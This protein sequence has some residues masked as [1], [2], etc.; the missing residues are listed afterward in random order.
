VPGSEC[1][2]ELFLFDY[3]GCHSLPSRKRKRGGSREGLDNN[4]MH[5]EAHGRGRTALRPPPQWHNRASQPPNPRVP[6][7]PS[8][9]TVPRAV[10][11]HSSRRESK[12]LY[13]ESSARVAHRV[14]RLWDR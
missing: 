3:E 7:G 5:V 8:T 12:R 4:T 6:S 13:W 1:C 2:N 14:H 10:A 9:Q 11:P